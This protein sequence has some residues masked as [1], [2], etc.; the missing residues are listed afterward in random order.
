MPNPIT[1]TLIIRCSL[2]RARRECIGRLIGMRVARMLSRSNRPSARVTLHPLVGKV[3]SDAASDESDSRQDA[4]SVVRR[5]SERAELELPPA[6]EPP[7]GRLDA[8]GKT[9]RRLVRGC[10]AKAARFG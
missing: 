10:A 1:P 3:A 2:A 6:F 8:A 7:A 4:R 9:A 5:A